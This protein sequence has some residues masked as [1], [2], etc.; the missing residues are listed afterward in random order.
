MLNVLRTRHLSILLRDIILN[1]TRGC[2]MA[3]KLRL[4]GNGGFYSGFES[5]IGL[6]GDVIWKLPDADGTAD[7]VLSTD[8]SAN[9]SWSDGGGGGGSQGPWVDISSHLTANHAGTVTWDYALGRFS[10]PNTGEY[11]FD[12]KLRLASTSTDTGDLFVDLDGA[13]VSQEKQSI[14]VD[15]TEGVATTFSKYATS[16]IVTSNP[17]PVSAIASTG[18]TSIPT[19]AWD[20]REPYI[21]QSGFAEEFTLASDTLITKAEIYLMGQDRI[22]GEVNVDIV[23]TL[24]D[25]AWP[26]TRLVDLGSVAVTAIP[27]D[28]QYVEFVAAAPVLLTAG[29]YYLRFYTSNWNGSNTVYVN[30]IVSGDTG[31]LADLM[32]WNGSSWASS[33]SDIVYKL[34]EGS[35]VADT[36]RMAWSTSDSRD[37]WNIDAQNLLMDRI[38]TWY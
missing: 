7:Q 13:E 30:K 29:T 28:F 18:G 22:S 34:Y 25:P 6:V 15:C 24:S 21:S 33:T 1:L 8:G 4:E 38:P 31:Y 17:T 35:A 5:N 19:D 9:L 14:Q 2:N 3:G 11:V 37:S 27:S 32:Y 10:E 20:L 36:T 16:G 12:T 23:S 26:G